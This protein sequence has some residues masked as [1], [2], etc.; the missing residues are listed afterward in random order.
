MR[1][2][3]CSFCRRSDSEVAKL[4][5]G[6][7]RLFVGRVYICDRCAA[8]TIKIMDAHSGDKQPPRETRSLFR[9]AVDRL[10]WNR[11]HDTITRSE[12]HAI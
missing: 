2:M 5:A 4:V 6:P 1:R 3:R 9:R 12:Y 7:L 8:Q 11:H 10:A